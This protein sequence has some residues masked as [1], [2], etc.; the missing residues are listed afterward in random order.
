MSYQASYSQKIVF[1]TGNRAEYFLLRPIIRVFEERG[2]WDVTVLV[3]GAHLDD[4]YGHTADLITED[5]W[6]QVCCV[7]IP[8]PDSGAETAS[9]IGVALTR[10]VPVLE[11]CD[12]KYLVVYADRFEGL[13]A[14][15]SGFHLGIN[16]IHVE[17]GDI[18]SGGAFDD[19]YRDVMS[20]FASIHWPTSLQAKARLIDLGVLEEDI[21]A[22][23]LPSL[24]EMEKATKV[25]AQDLS[26]E[27]G[28][29]ISENSQII[30]FTYH[31][32]PV[33]GSDASIELRHCLAALGDWITKSEDRF[34][35]VSY[36]NND[37]GGSNIISI[38]KEFDG[39][40]SRIVLRDTFG[41]LNIFSIYNLGAH[42]VRSLCMGNSSSGIKEASAFGCPVV[43]VGERQNGRHRTPN[44]IDVECESGAIL[45]ALDRAFSSDFFLSCR[46]VKSPYWFGGAARLALEDLEKRE[47]GR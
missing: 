31:S 33:L 1:F 34:V 35:L 3:S 43:N 28:I 9:A 37:A 15:I 47:L 21:C 7:D 18:T 23:G 45:E 30:L 20:R 13:A 36:P 10:Y 41:L 38:I 17:G 12:P 4:S 27:L 5:G 40:S 26:I 14:V 29:D 22:I 46:Q 42:G 44:I 8:S 25:R 2:Y 6:E 24:D 32:I 16:V 39:T 11:S 19:T